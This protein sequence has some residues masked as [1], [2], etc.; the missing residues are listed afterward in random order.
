MTPG[1]RNKLRRAAKTT[2]EEFSLQSTA[3]KALSI[4]R[5]MLGRDISRPSEDDKALR[6][7]LQLIKAEWDL[8]MGMAG[9]AGAALT[10][11]EEEA[12]APS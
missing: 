12:D 1:Q 9:A 3:R 6:G 11:D 10:S 7:T 5:S 4:Y 8:L 2:A